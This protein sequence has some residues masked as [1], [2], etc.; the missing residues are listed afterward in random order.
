MYQGTKTRKP[1]RI[2]RE[3]QTT[4]YRQR[5]PSVLTRLAFG[6]WTIMANVLE[7][8]AVLTALIV[9]MLACL[10]VPLLIWF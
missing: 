3:G 8:V 5:K 2:K 7:A 4:Y 10:I 6:T 9:F 1:R